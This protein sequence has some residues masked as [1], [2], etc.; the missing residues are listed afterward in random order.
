MQPITS[1]C[2]ML[3]LLSANFGV[4]VSVAAKGRHVPRRDTLLTLARPVVRSESSLAVA[5]GPSMRSESSL[6]AVLALRGGAKVG[7][8]K[9]GPIKIDVSMNPKWCVYTNAFAG[10]L[11]ALSL[12]GLDPALPDPTLKYWQEEQTATT[13]CILQ[14]FALTLVWINGFMVYAMLVLN[15]PATGLLKFQ[16]AGWASTLALLCY[17]VQHYGFIAQQDTLGIMLT[18]FGV[19]AYLGYA[20]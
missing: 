17:Q 11:Y 19:S 20:P 12:L 18:L 10:I 6:P 5:L 13:R 8:I 9:L 14:Y 16:C 15:A 4:T 3:V 7:P 2:A 1:V